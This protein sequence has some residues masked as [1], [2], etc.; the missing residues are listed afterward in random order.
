ME[1]LTEHHAN[2]FKPPINIKDNRNGQFQEE[3]FRF[4]KRSRIDRL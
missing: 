2:T 1:G 3:E 4:F